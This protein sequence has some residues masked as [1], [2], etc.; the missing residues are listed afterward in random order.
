MA[1]LS[2]EDSANERT[3]VVRSGLIAGLTDELSELGWNEFELLTTERALSDASGDLR[4]AASAIHPRR[5]S[6]PE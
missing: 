6:W 5:P 1:E 3:V 2:W 4:D